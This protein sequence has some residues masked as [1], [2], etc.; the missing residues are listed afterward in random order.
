MISQVPRLV[1]DRGVIRQACKML[2]EALKLKF[3]EALA[4][5]QDP[6]S[7]QKK[8]F[9][10]SRLKRVKGTRL[11][12]YTLDIEPTSK[13]LFYLQYYEGNLYLRELVKPT[14]NG[15]KTSLDMIA[16]VNDF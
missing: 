13:W 12:I 6:E 14:N 3:L 7:Y 1:D 5:L 16:E 2:P 11:N 8:Y 15:P 10:V 4:E 9:P